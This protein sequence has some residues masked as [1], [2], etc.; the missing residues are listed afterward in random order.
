[1]QWMRFPVWFGELFTGAKS[2]KA[3]PLIGND[4]LNRYGLHVGVIANVKLTP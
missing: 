3:N 2:F 1:M 4:H